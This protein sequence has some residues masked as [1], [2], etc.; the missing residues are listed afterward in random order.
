MTAL[1]QVA[2]GSRLTAAMVRAV[3]PN[4]A[5]KASSQPVTSSTTLVA[6]SALVIPVTAN[7]IYMFEQVLFYQ[8]GVQ[9]SSD[10]KFNWALPAGSTMM[11]AGA[12]LTPA[13]VQLSGIVKTSSGFQAG[14][15][16]VGV[17]VSVYVFGTLS[18]GSSAGTCQL[19]WAQNTSSATAT[20]ILGGSIMSAWQV[21]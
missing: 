20:Q 7:S 8:G 21:Q 16:G 14:A 15:N 18:V 5:Y 3:A 6:D 12:G 1:A 10:L 17:Q 4:A 11:L 9:G 2:A 19:M 13:G